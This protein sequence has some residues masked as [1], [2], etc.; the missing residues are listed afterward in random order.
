MHGSKHAHLK[1]TFKHPTVVLDQS[2]H[3]TDIKCSNGSI[4]ICF[5]NPKARDI[6]ETSWVENTHDGTFHLLTYHLGCGDLSGHKRSYFLAFQPVQNTGASCVSVPVEP[7]D[8][9][10][11]LE[12]GEVSWGM[13]EDPKELR[14]TLPAPRVHSRAVSLFKRADDGG[15]VDIENDLAALEHFFNVTV[16]PNMPE[17]E[18]PIDFVEDDGLVD[19]DGFVGLPDGSIAQRDSS[20]RP[21]RKKKGS[22]DPTLGQAALG[23]LKVSCHIHTIQTHTAEQ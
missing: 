20:A 11:A 14:R 7:I 18:D 10:T 16:D 1:A 8:E 23:F 12:S 9:E 6:V 5:E 21:R 2:N 19:D 13:Y 17:P 4:E 3:V 22:V 15:N